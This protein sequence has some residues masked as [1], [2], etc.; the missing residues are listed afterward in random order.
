MRVTKTYYRGSGFYGN[1]PTKVEMRDWEPR[2]KPVGGFDDAYNGEIRPLLADELGY[3][4][5]TVRKRK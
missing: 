3:D 2:R 5:V 4:L 1:H